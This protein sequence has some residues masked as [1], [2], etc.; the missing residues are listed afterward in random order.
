MRTTKPISTI[1]F[2]N[3]SYL[4]LQLDTLKK[5]K[6]I[7]FWA[8][9][10]HKPEDDEA[11]KKE[12]IHLYIEPSL[13]IQTEDLKEFFKEYNPNDISKPFG[14]IS[15]VSSKFDHWYMYSI[16]NKG[17]LASKGQ[18]RR[19]HYIHDDIVSS[20]YD[21][22][23]CKSRMIDMLSLSVYSDMQDAIYNGITFDE[24]FRRGTIPIQ[25]IK[26][27]M[28]AWSLLTIPKTYRDEKT[29]HFIDNATGEIIN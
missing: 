23:L 4:K 13:L 10:K 22:L 24:Y 14:C 11:G 5:S 21:E 17:Y 12:H 19:Y 1:S 9:I 15:I 29:G 25:Q 27:Y 16:H 6:K 7:S 18:S 3:E 20:D 28:T 2:N 26:N 8:Y